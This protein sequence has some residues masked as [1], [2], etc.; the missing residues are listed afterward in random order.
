MKK[1]NFLQVSILT[2]ILTV[3]AFSGVK[4]QCDVPGYIPSSGHEFRVDDISDVDSYT[5]YETVLNTPNYLST[6]YSPKCGANPIKLRYSTSNNAN[7]KLQMYIELWKQSFDCNGNLTGSQSFV[8]STPAVEYSGNTPAINLYLNVNIEANTSYQIRVK[9]RLKT[10]GI[11][12]SY[13]TDYSN[14]IR[15]IASTA[16]PNPDGVFIDELSVVSRSGFNGWVVDVH[17]LDVNGA[18]DFDASLTSCENNWR[19]SISEFN[20]STWT[21]TNVVSTG[22][23]NGQAGNIDLD[24]FYTPGLV[25]GKLYMVSVI[26][27]FGWYPKNF[28][29]EIKDAGICGSISENG[30]VT[31]NILLPNGKIK[32]YKLYKRCTLN[33]MKLYTDCSESVDEY[34]ITVRPVDA[35]YNQSGA[36]QTT[37][38]VSGPV[39][40]EYNLGSMFG[41][42]TTGQRYEIIYQVR[43][44]LK[45]RRFY[46]R[47]ETCKLIAHQPLFKTKSSIVDQAE[48]SAVDVYPNPS[49]GNFFVELG[50]TDNV[51]TVEVMDLRGRVVFSQQPILNGKINIDLNAHRKGIYLVR[52]FQ[53]NELTVKKLIKQ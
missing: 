5:K 32:Q 21:A 38:W 47:Y 8:L 11:Y 51:A 12:G 34:K 31:E 50:N 27:G 28:W 2:L 1:F 35:S 4:A 39:A 13:N 41:A 46:F 25:K 9:R 44:S 7:R 49:T 30:F 16:L 45:T 40:S 20:L 17:Q 22:L 52:I 23:I 42:F 14:N 33:S 24:A 43:N 26:A 18:L 53:N 15:F 3:F 29:F 10:L 48:E 36:L 6:Y 19:Y 37:N